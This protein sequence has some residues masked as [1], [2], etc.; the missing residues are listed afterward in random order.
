L[1]YFSR[2]LVDK[3]DSDIFLVITE[4]DALPSSA[5]V[6]LTIV[7]FLAFI[8][9]PFFLRGLGINRIHRAYEMEKQLQKD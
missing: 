4:F 1:L 2:L 6:Y 9:L 7:F 3:D 8:V 5:R